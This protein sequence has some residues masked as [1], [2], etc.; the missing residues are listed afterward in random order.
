MKDYFKNNLFTYNRR[1]SIPVKIGNIG[2]GGDNPIRIQSMTTTDT[3]DTNATV[4]QSIR[5]INAGCELVRVTAPSINDAKNLKNIKIELEKKGYNI[6]VVADIHFTPNAAEIAAEIVEKVRIN[7]GNYADK[8]KFQQI[9]Y[10]D[11]SYNDEIE[12][13]YER[14]SP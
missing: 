6:P 1:K 4:D 8:K 3:M 13:I 2:I 10:D 9:E 7:P 12:R 14:V 5:M 11:R